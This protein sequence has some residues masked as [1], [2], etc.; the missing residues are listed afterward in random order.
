ML[1]R[2]HQARCGFN[3][4]ARV[5]AGK[6]SEYSMAFPGDA[7]NGA[8]A[9]GEIF[10]A[11]E[12]V[13]AHAS[14]HEFYGAVV[15]EAEALGRVSDGDGSILRRAGHLEEQLVLLRLEAC[16]HGGLLTEEEEAAQLEAEVR[17]SADE[18]MG[19]AGFGVSGHVYIVTRYNLLLH[20][21][22]ARSRFACCRGVRV[23]YRSTLLHAKTF[24]PDDSIPRTGQI[25][26]PVGV[27]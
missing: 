17:Q 4:F 21:V 8:A 12:Q 25:G 24:Y 27:R 13:L 23:D 19:S 18:G 10:G 7:E 16:F 26:T 5:F 9:V 20:F 22:R 2:S 11:F 14:V 6:A 1:K 15:P 3:E